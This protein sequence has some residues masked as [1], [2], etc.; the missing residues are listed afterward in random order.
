M[1]FPNPKLAEVFAVTAVYVQSSSM[2]E[3]MIDKTRFAASNTRNLE[4]A[5]L[6]RKRNL[7]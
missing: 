5:T 7:I 6:I 2:G 4:L 3:V 1:H